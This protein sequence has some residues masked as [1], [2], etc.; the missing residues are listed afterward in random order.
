MQCR[1]TSIYAFNHIR[2]SLFV[3]YGANFNKIFAVIC[4][5]LMFKKWPKNRNFQYKMPFILISQFVLTVTTT[6]QMFTHARSPI[7]H[8][9]PVLV[10]MQNDDI[11][12]PVDGCC[13]KLH[14][15]PYIASVCCSSRSTGS[16]AEQDHCLSGNSETFK[17]CI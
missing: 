9:C 8:C 1:P 6:V 4:E 7:R 5:I 15:L 10:K 12:P 17:H 16:S 2:H 13:C 11:L 14:G 3:P